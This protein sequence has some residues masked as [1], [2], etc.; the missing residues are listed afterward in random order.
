MK[1]FV[2]LDVSMKETAV[3]VVDGSG[4]RIWEGSVPRLRTHSLQPEDYDDC[5]GDGGHEHVR[6]A[7]VARVDTS[8]VFEF[9]EHIFDPL[10]GRACLHTREGCDGFD[11]TPYHAGYGFFCLI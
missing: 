3:C 6:A 7:V 9:A 2:G 4:Q 8:P 11:S 1:H 5:E 10:P